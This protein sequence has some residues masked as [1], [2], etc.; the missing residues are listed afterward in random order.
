LRRDTHGYRQKKKRKT[1][2]RPQD[3]PSGKK[4]NLLGKPGKKRKEQRKD[5]ED[6]AMKTIKQTAAP[7]GPFALICRKK[8]RKMRRI[9][10]D[11]K[12]GDSAGSSRPCIWSGRGSIKHH[13]SPMGRKKGVRLAT[14]EERR[15]HKDQR[16][17]MLGVLKYLGR[18]KTA[19]TPL[20][21][22]ARRSY[23]T[24]RRKEK[25]L[26]GQKSMEKMNLTL[27]FQPRATATRKKKG[28]RRGLEKRN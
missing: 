11:L 26:A 6:S 19:Y 27:N 2:P 7:R 15:P 20:N 18:R 28:G 12:K 4:A 21:E 22:E 10:D 3:A 16:K 5:R 25:N 1:R 17:R 23:A 8:K 24:T 14:M 13:D 9:E